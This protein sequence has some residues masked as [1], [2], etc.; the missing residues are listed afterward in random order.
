MTMPDREA[1]GRLRLLL[2]LLTR[3]RR[4]RPEQPMPAGQVL[5]AFVLTAALI[6]LGVLL[7]FL[8]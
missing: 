7:L 1:R 6:G 8:R 4:Q 3:R 5:L 2:L